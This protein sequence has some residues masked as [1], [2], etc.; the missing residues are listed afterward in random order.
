[1]TQV[2]YPQTATH[3]GSLK[4]L[5]ASVRDPRVSIG[6]GTYG[7]FPFV[8][9]SADD[10]IEIGRYCSIAGEVR[11]MGGGEHNYRTT[12]TF[13]FYTF[14]GEDPEAEANDPTRC[15]IAMQFIRALPESVR[16][17][18]SGTERQSFQASDRARRGHWRVGSDRLRRP[19]VRHHGRQPRAL[20]QETV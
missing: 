19:S 14:H 8:L 2:N 15:V 12:S 20:H 9:Y 11:I 16:T 10:R 18:G 3:S 13:P 1:M 17:S 4:E 6:R 7:G 5:R